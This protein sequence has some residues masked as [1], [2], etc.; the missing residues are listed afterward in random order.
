MRSC[1]FKQESTE[2]DCLTEADQCK[3]IQCSDKKPFLT[4]EK[5]IRKEM[6]KCIQGYIASLPES[7]RVA[8]I[9]SEIEGMKNSEIASILGLML[10]PKSVV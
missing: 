4:E 7:Y 1:S 9:L 5:V 3:K 8:I 10:L 2:T 6:N